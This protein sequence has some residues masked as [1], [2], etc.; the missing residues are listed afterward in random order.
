MAEEVLD[1]PS[2][3]NPKWVV[4]RCPWDNNL[5]TNMPSH[6]V[7]PYFNTSEEADAYLRKHYPGKGYDYGV[8]KTDGKHFG[9]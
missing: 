2:R 5:K 3:S 1:L 9:I 6:G 7:S 8:F 4:V